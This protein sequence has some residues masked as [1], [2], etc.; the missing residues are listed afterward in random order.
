MR[1]KKDCLLSFLKESKTEKNLSFAKYQGEKTHTLHWRIM[2]LTK[3]ANKQELSVALEKALHLL[4]E[5]IYG[6]IHLAATGIH[7]APATAH[8]IVSQKLDA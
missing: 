1:Q 2:P 5:A 4:E 7:D 8:I 6:G 3:E